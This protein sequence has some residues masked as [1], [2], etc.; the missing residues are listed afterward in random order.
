MA[1]AF[2]EYQTEL[3][4]LE[5]KRQAAID[6]LRETL[7]EQKAAVR[8]TEQQLEQLQGGEKLARRKST[9]VMTAEHKEKL[10]LAREKKK[11]ERSKRS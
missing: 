10:R 8:N 5:G 4:K 3:K 9:Y 2:A 11:Q 7:K 6:A 1:D